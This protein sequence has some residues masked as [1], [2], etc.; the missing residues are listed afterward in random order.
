MMYIRS[1]VIS[2]EI[3]VNWTQL[4]KLSYLVV[5]QHILESN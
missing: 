4:T 2:K 3:F 1:Y 5:S